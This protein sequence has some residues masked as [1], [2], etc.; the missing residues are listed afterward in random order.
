MDGVLAR[1]RHEADVLDRQSALLR[2]LRQAGPDG[3][4]E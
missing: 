1:L 2:D 3:F 4:S